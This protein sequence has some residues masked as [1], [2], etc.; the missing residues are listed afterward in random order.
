MRRIR[1]VLLGL[2]LVGASFA[3]TL[4]EASAACEGISNAFAYNDCLAKQG[5][6]RGT[7]APRA[8][9]GVDPEATV[10]GKARYSPSRESI[11]SAGSGGVAISRSRNRTR[12]VIDPW[13][14]IKRT[15][16]PGPKKRRR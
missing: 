15:F 14:S 13:G 16:A 6:A 3:F 1:S 9:R 10:R 2:A 12:A 7:R 11:G 5:P 4:R 8:G